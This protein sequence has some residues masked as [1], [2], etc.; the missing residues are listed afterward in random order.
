MFFISA[1]KNPI[2]KA[3][4]ATRNFRTPLTL[5]NSK[6]SW[7]EIADNNYVEHDYLLIVRLIDKWGF[8][9]TNYSLVW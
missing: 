3:L 5:Y 4:E 8:I 2:I 1:Y 7:K 6:N 9:G